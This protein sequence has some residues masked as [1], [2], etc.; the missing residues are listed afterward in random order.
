MIS[1]FRS[2]RIGASPIDGS[3]ISSSF[4]RDISARPI[5]TIC[6]SPPDSVPASCER[7]SMQQREQLV[8][9]VE[10][11]L[12]APAAQVGAH[13]E[14]LEH[15]HRR[16]QPAVLRDDREAAADAVARRPRGDVLAV[17]AHG[18]VARPDDAEDRLQRRRLARRVA[19]EQ[20]DE[21]ARLDRDRQP[22]QDVD[23]A[24][25]GVDRVELA[26]RLICAR[27]SRARDTPRSTFSFVATC[28]NDPSA[29][30]TPWSSAITRS[31]MPSTTCMS[32]S[33]TRI[34]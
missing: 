15:R 17:D 9:P 21:L 29:I 3:S 4:G 12:G 19:A 10:V 14:V 22:L 28:S 30:L 27:P 2:T 33:I 1:K 31:E 13:L 26:G 24:V 25:V 18:A 34:V 6:C 8:D 32:C 7:R 20:A 16:E 11:L 23:L 5:A